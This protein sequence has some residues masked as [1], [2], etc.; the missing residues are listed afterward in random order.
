MTLGSRMKASQRS[1]KMPHEFMPRTE[2]PTTPV[3]GAQVRASANT[4]RLIISTQ[5]Y[6]WGILYRCT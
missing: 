4:G 3:K 6:C 1:A 2:E 5:V